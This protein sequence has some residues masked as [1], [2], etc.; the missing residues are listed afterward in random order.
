LRAIDATH[1]EVI[2]KIR[3]ETNC[4]E[5]NAE[6]MRYPKFRRQHL[7]VG[8]GGIEAGCKTVVGSRLKQSGMFWI[9]RGA[10]ARRGGWPSG[11]AISTANSRITGSDAAPHDSTSMS[12]TPG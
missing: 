2:E 4:L 1:P 12:R 10:N 8:T 3:I 11:A 9:V 5:R 7:F 6:R